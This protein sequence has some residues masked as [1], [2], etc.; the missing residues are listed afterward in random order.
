MKGTEGSCM[1]PMRQQMMQNMRAGMKDFNPMGL[2]QAMMTS[3]SNSTDMAAY[4]TPETR[5]LFEEWAR[6]VE[7]DIETTLK[8]TGP[9]DLDRLA[10]RFQMSRDS[11]LYLVGRLVRDGKASISSIQAT[12]TSPAAG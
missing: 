4:A 2:C 7:N 5:P 10:A 11:V 3:L 1:S 6:S 8:E 9:I 12:G